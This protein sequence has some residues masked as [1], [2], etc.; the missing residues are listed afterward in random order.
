M[1]LLARY[2]SFHEIGAM[3]ILILALYD[4][5]LSLCH[6]HGYL[7]AAFDLKRSIRQRC[8]LSILLYLTVTS[9]LLEMQHHALRGTQL[10]PGTMSP[11]ANDVKLFMSRRYTRLYKPLN[12]ARVLP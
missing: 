8:P 2:E 3:I 5:A 12:V 1:Y 6:V 10:K 9:L 7:S 11:N 4:Q